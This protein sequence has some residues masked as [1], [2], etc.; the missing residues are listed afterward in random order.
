MVYFLNMNYSN[1]ENHKT[2]TIENKYICAI[3][4]IYEGYNNYSRTEK[5]FTT[6]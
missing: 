6:A 5:S 1:D 4:I 3:V 2:L